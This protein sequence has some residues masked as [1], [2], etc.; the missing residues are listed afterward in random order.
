VPPPP[1]HNHLLTP[2]S[3]IVPDAMHMLT[4]N[5]SIGKLRNSG[6]PAQIR[7]LPVNPALQVQMKEPG[8]LVHRAL[9]S[10]GLL[11]DSH[12]LI[13][14]TAWRHDLYAWYFHSM[15][16]TSMHLC[17]SWNCWTTCI[18]ADHVWYSGPTFH[19]YVPFAHWL[20]FSHALI[21]KQRLSQMHMLIQ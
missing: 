3:D 13:S 19:S 11:S 14:S 8:V 2:L 18:N 6:I 20:T 17:S 7:P 21:N 9:A 15:S 1:F 12:S 16:W 10:Q 5:I 4:H